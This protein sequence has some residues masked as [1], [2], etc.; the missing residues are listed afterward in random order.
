M[1]QKTFYVPLP[2]NL[3][4]KKQ[5]QETKENSLELNLDPF[6]SYSFT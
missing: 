6:S 1:C 3:L 5:K 4:L 2:Y